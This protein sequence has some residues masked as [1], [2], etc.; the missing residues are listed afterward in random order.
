M[1][2][3]V[4]DTVRIKKQIFGLQVS[5]DEVRSVNDY[6][7]FD[8]VGIGVHVSFSFPLTRCF[9]VLI[10]IASGA[11]MCVKYVGEGPSTFQALTYLSKP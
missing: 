4:N 6:E 5:M 7:G 1:N 8:V 2:T 9:L 3:N 11:E 10:L